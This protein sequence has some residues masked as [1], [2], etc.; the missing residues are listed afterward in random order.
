[1]AFERLKERQAYVWGAAPFEKIAETIGPMHD[2][3]VE[4]LAPQPGERW[5][6]VGTGT[7]EVAFRAARAGAD[8]TGSDLSPALI[9]TAKRQGAEQGLTVRFEVGDAER[10]PYGDASFDVVSSSVGMIFAPDHAAVASELAR[11]VRPGG[12]V[13]FTAWRKSSGVG[14]FF[15]AM[16]PFQAPPPEGAGSPLA[17]GDEPYVAELLGEA[18]ELRFEEHDVPHEGP[19][20]EAIWANMIEGFGPAR[21]LSESLE[22]DRRA[23]L[24]RTMTELLERDRDGDAIRQERL[25][26]V[27]TGT[28]R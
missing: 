25:Y 2:A 22:P 24:D 23:E 9:E 13:G 17:W 18:F 15:A 26:L 16:A 10:L 14:A 19:S 5:L 21:V 27:V 20:G 12:R 28:R 4:A 6:D 1:V 11:V 8:V 7:G 3:L